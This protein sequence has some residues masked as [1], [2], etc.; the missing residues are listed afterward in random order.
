MQRHIVAQRGGGLRELNC[1]E[2][3]GIHVAAAIPGTPPARG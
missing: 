1:S 2:G 3:A